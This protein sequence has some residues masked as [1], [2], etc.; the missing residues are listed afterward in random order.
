MM[1]VTRLLRSSR[2]SALTVCLLAFS[3][4]VWV[5]DTQDLKQFTLEQKARPSGRI[6][7]LPEFKAYESFVYEG[8]SLRDPFRPLTQATADLVQYGDETDLQPDQERS[9]EYLEKFSIDV[10][11]MVGTIT[12]PGQDGI[13]AL[14]KD[15]NSEVH[16]VGV[17]DFLGNDYGQIVSIDERNL[18]LV[19]IIPNGRGGWMKRPRRLSLEQQD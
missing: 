9:K 16:Q 4:C 5:N 8:S 12:H 18:E 7:P 3:G 2:L 13:W 19:E 14:I 15:P 1:T 17:G 10:L 11:K 6:E